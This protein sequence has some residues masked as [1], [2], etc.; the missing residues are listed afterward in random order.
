MIEERSDTSFG[1][2]ERLREEALTRLK[3][4]TDFHTHV[5]AYVLINTFLVGIWAVTGSGF[6]A[7]S[8]RSSAGASGWR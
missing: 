8:P 4:K 5:L 3:K 6:L 7:G 1:P 2:D